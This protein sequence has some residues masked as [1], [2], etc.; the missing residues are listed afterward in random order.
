LTADEQAESG[1]RRPISATGQA[2]SAAP[3]V[4]P[5]PQFRPLRSDAYEALREAILL[6]RLQPGERIVEAEIAR[7][8]GISRGPIREAVRQLEQEELV[9]YQ[10]RRGVV[11]ARL[12]HEAVRDTYAVRAELD[13]FAARLA[14]ARI[15]DTQLAH[16][17]SLIG[18]MRR[19]AHADD[20][21][22]LLTTDVEFHRSIYT[23]A[24]NKVLQRAWAN[25]GPHAWTLF[26]GL[27]LR[28]YSL[29][30]LAE[31]HLSIVQALRTHDPLTAERAAREH[32]LEIARNVLDH[33][34]DTTLDLALD[35]LHTI[36]PGD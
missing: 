12:S 9:E 3:I 29:R 19:Q 28:G 31:R 36:K 14:A 16:L 4:A 30:D 34:G 18:T 23:V 11:V 26:S 22:A 20:H 35:S 17:D 32:T 21:E 1:V 5:A 7:Q 13:G 27:Q 25:L 8:M 15:T 33:L 6:R 24:G 2:T 10:P